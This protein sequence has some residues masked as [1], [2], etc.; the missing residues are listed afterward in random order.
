MNIRMIVRGKRKEYTFI[1]SF[2][3]WRMYDDHLIADLFREA[4]KEI[5]KDEA[6]ADE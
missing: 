3:E 6:P 4:M 1:H 2:S 5:K